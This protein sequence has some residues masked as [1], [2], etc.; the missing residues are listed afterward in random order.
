MTL[1]GSRVMTLSGPGGVT[2]KG[3]R[4]MTLSRPWGVT[5][6]GPCDRFDSGKKLDGRVCWIA[7]VFLPCVVEE[8]ALSKVLCSSGVIGHR[9]SC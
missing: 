2:L 1:R 6:R 4:G 9:C 8:N 3:P 5:L 7:L